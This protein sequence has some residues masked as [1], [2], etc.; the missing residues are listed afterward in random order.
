MFCPPA[1]L[2]H[3][4]GGARAADGGVG[5]AGL[6]VR[7][8]RLVLEEGDI[9]ARGQLAEAAG[10]HALARPGVAAEAQHR[11]QR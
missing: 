7:E 10:V 6:G 3:K 2:G 11:D 4:R 5:G 1:F 8:G 9:A